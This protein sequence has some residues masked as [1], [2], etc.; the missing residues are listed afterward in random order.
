MIAK[1]DQKGTGALTKPQAWREKQKFLVGMGSLDENRFS[2]GTDM[3]IAGGF[4][5]VSRIPD[6][7]ILPCQNRFRN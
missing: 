7:D 1:P 4:R 2:L 3:S 5:F 6:P